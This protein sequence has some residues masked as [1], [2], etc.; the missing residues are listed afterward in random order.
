MRIKRFFIQVAC[1]LNLFSFIKCQKN[2]AN[3]EIHNGKEIIGTNNKIKITM[4]QN[5]NKKIQCA[6]M[7]LKRSDCNMALLQGQNCFIYFNCDFSPNFK[8]NR[9][10]VSIVKKLRCTK[11]KYVEGKNKF[12]IDN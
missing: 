4:K 11:D 7:C 9:D 6:S 2:E 10:S 8:D 12:F 1:F 5:I 3:Y